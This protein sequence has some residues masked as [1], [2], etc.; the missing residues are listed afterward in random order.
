MTVHEYVD[1]LKEE[2]TM[3]IN[4]DWFFIIKGASKVLAFALMHN[5]GSNGKWFKLSMEY[6]TQLRIINYLIR[7]GLIKRKIQGF[8]RE[9]FFQIDLKKL[10][11]LE[12]G[13]KHGKS[14]RNRT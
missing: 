5:L 3:W 13:I 14:K 1:S 6:Q 9:R 11:Q 7:K 8:P 12:K 10:K 4:T 2:E